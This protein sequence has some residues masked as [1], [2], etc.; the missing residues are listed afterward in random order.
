MVV[1][2]RMATVPVAPLESAAGPPVDVDR[3]IARNSPDWARLEGLARRGAGSLS[4]D[5]V[6]EMVALYQRTSTHL[7]HARTERADPALV[8]RLTRTAP[9]ASGGTSTTTP[10]PPSG[11]PPA[12]HLEG[13]K[14]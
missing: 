6:Q 14:R 7:T 8:A 1:G 10:P 13:K 12:E 5:E 3:F 11:A 4:P 2:I 9:T